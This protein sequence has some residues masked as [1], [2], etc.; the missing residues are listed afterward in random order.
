MRRSLARAAFVAT[1]AM[2][3]MCLGGCKSSGKLPGKDSKEYA[4]AVS[5]FY[6]GLGAL[7]VGDD[8]HAESE[9]SKL[10]KLAPGEPAGWGNWGVLALRQRKLD[11]AGERFERALK[12]APDNDQIYQMMG[13]LE[14]SR[15]DS[16]K[17]I[18]DW[19][20]AVEI[21]PRNYR[22]AYQL[23]EEVERQ[24]GANS[25][26]EYRTL[27][28]KI[29]ESQPDNLAAELELCR[30]AAKSGDGALVKSVLTKIASRSSGWPSEVKD[31]FAALQAAANG[32]NPRSAATRT[33][34]LRNTLMRVPEFR[35]ELAVLKA[36]P[37]EEAEP[38][39]KFLRMERPNFRPAAA[40]M[41]LTFDVKPAIATDSGTWSWIGAVALGSE[42]KPIVAE[43][44]G[45]EV[46][47]ASG[48]SFPFPGGAENAGPGP[49][50][51]LQADFNYDFKTDL[52]LAGAGGVKFMRQDSPEKFTDV[53]AATKLP[54]NILSAAYTGAWAVDIEADGD[55][56]IVLGKKDGAPQVLRNNGDGTFV[57]IQPFA[58]ISGA[59]EFAWADF[60]GDGNPDAAIVD[61]EDR[62]HLFHNQRQGQF[63][64]VALPGELTKIKAIGVA[65]TDDDGVLNLVAVESNGTIASVGY[66]EKRGWSVAALLQ[67]PNAT[68]N[69]ASDVR[70]LIADLDNNGA[71]DLVLSP[72]KVA[73]GQ[74][75]KPLIWLGDANAKYTLLEQ[76]SGL[77]SVF[78]IADLNGDG[79]LNLLGFDSG[80]KPAVGVSRGTKNYHWQVIRPHARQATGDQR[81]N[82]FGVGGEIE[83]R[84]GLLVQ[85]QPINGPQLHFGLGNQ[86]S[87]DAMRIVWPNGS[88]RAE[89]S[90]PADQAVLTE[91]RIKGS[92]PYLFAFNGKG[93]EF[94][95]D[96]VP[97]SSAIGLRINTVGTARVEA[98]EE[99]YKIGPDELV[100]HDGYY[101]MR[102]TAELWETYYYDY[103]AMMVVDHPVGTEIYVDERFVI[104]PAKLAITATETPHKIVSAVDDDGHDVTDIVSTLD[105]KYLDNF[106]RGQYQGVTR[107]HYVEVDLGND[108][109]QSGPVWLIAKGWMHPTDSSINVAI[110]QGKHET[111]RGL[112]L[113]V[114]DGHGGW[115][116]AKSNL[117]FPAGRKKICLFDLANIFL[118]GTPHRVRL[119]T[120][121][122]IYWDS[123]E[124]AKGLPDTQLKTVKL[125]PTVADLHY[126]GYSV[127]NQANPSSPE[128]PDYNHF[129]GSK[130]RWRDL[131]GYYTRYGDVR[132]LLGKIDDRYVIMNSGDE[133][134]FRFAE[135]PAPSGGWK[136]DYLIIG[137]GW[138]KD[139]DYNS[140]FSR[141]V[142]P[143]PYHA[144]NLYDTAPGR[145][146]DEYVYKRHPEDWEKY[147]TRYVTPDVFKNSMRRLPQ[148]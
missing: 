95:K 39:T 40:D 114:P 25:E 9:L 60:D 129:E 48:A 130:Q 57:A 111:A 76:A 36:P 64:E 2:L 85:K 91:Q 4:Q 53:T 42:G 31:Q 80:G 56:D 97:W 135:Q 34:F 47:L 44:N 88:V 19:R 1:C 35:E 62:L 96:A 148:Q 32:P 26:A 140:G 113:E 120:N 118:P 52:V 17:A 18:A 134:T 33:T 87:T 51:I 121:L 107:D 66:S 55:L 144:K 103:L 124:W 81:I 86:T 143:L 38:F 65:D 24:G 117:G 112:S 106:G 71:L 20:K 77:A 92:C 61:G 131:V 27:I 43:A 3:V 102:I 90:L 105:G 23:A 54:K 75:E 138:I 78:S 45:K 41:A 59:K 147:H 122:E 89:F 29:L 146:E 13:F 104:P 145:L 16:A 100:P 123:I 15:G 7:Q 141:T 142:E 21:N 101:D 110:G 11:V 6:V 136:R 58:G 83:I 94:V 74:S 28:E 73:A 69:L 10:T 72:A 46:R 14:S 5:A 30:I 109:P 115:A 133:M 79:R 93:V 98:T 67:V 139:G 137:D 82:P 125:D 128:I 68:A 132:E 49:E 70:L 108:V 8:V 119:R 99:W 116:V 37:G 12:L 126:R 63:R 84:S 22:A 50:G 127:M